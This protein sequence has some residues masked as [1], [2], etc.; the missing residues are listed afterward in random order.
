[1]GRAERRKAGKTE[2]VKTYCMTEQQIEKIKRDAAEKALEEM[3]PKIVGD[4]MNKLFIMF[5][6]IPGL[7]L[8]DKFGFGKVRMDRFM[9]Y[10][11][12]W[13]DSVQNGETELD[14]LIALA[15]EATG[16]KFIKK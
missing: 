7:V 1:M 15:E 10:A 12:I 16:C 13:Y 2:K 14:E 11:L 8:S 5:M 9:N 6:S 4:M 3:K